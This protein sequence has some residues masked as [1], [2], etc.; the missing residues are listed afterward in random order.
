M[1]GEP[2]GTACRSVKPAKI[3]YV[4]IRFPGVI[5]QTLPATLLTA[6]GPLAAFRVCRTGYWAALHPAFHTRTL[7]CQK[8]PLWNAKHTETSSQIPSCFSLKH[9][10]KFSFC[11]CAPACISWTAPCHQRTMRSNPPEKGSEIYTEARPPAGNKLAGRP[12]GTPPASPL[13]T[14]GCRPGHSKISK[15]VSYVKETNQN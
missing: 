1:L 11:V 4:F 13:Q 6:G 5:Q 15:T 2:S 9:W 8:C 14:T 7:K 3:L 12:A 10:L